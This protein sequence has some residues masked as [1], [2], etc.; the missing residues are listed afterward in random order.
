MANLWKKLQEGKPSD[1]RTLLKV[2]TEVIS[3]L[4]AFLKD[5]ITDVFKC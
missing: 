2:L 3:H 1:D 4:G 5:E